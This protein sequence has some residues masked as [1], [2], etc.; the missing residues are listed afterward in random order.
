M[1]FTQLVGTTSNSK[2]LSVTNTSAAA[3]SISSISASGNFQAVGAG[4]TPCGGSLAAGTKCTIAVSFSPSINTTIT[5]AVAIADGTSVSPQVYDLTGYG[6]LPLTSSASSLTFA[7][8]AVG[9]TSAPQTVTLTN[10]QSTALNIFVAA[11][12]QYAVTPSGTG[13]CGAS[14]GAGANCTFNVTFTPS[15]VGTI[16]GVVTLGFG[17]SPSPLDVKLTGTGQ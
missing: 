9:T 11:S 4:T 8:Q 3:V 12:G 5:G 17:A 16:Q 10:R 15:T 6:V 14:L 2:T 1:S 13:P 7:A